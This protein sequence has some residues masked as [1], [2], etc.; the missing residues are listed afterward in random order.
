MLCRCTARAGRGDLDQPARGRVRGGRGRRRRPRGMNRPHVCRMSA[1][2]PGAGARAL[3]QRRRPTG[4]GGPS[5]PSDLRLLPAPC[6]PPGSRTPAR[7]GWCPGRRATTAICSTTH[8]VCLAR[9]RGHGRASPVT[10]KATGAPDRPTDQTIERRC[11]ADQRGNASRSPAAATLATPSP[12]PPARPSGRRAV[13]A[14]DPP[15]LPRPSP[16]RRTRRAGRPGR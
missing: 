13:R 3:G 15:P 16:R 9:R 8:V 4:G 10:V 5:T 11:H 14:A 1:S 12:P 6:A 2:G 7:R